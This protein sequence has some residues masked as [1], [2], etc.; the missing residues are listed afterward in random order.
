MQEILRNTITAEG[1]I[2]DAITAGSIWTE[3]VNVIGPKGYMSIGNELVSIDPDSLSRTVL[4]P[5]G[6]TITRP[7]GALYM[8]NGVPRMDLEVQK[9][10]Q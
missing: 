1:I 8:V 2:A 3:N 9:H 5:T 7:D 10:L 4:S 6:L